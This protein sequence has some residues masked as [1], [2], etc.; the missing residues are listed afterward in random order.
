MSTDRTDSLPTGWRLVTLGDCIEMVYGKGLIGTARRA[1]PIPVY[2]SNGVVGTHDKF[3]SLG[4]TIVIGRK[5]SVGEVHFSSSPCWPIDTTY[6]INSFG[7]FDPLFLFYLLRSLRLGEL[8]KST[9]IPGLRRTD[10][11]ALRVTLPP[12]VEQRQIVK[13]VEQVLA[14]INVV[15]QRLAKVTSLLKRFRQAVLAAG[16]AGRLTVDWRSR[17]EVTENGNTLANRI[18][19]NHGYQLTGVQEHSS[20]IP[21]KWGQATLGSL[22]A[23]G[24]NKKSFVT[25]GSRGW[26]DLVGATGSYFIRS[27]C[28]NNDVLR[29]DDLVRINAPPGSESERTRV[30]VNDL[31]LTI[32]GNNVGRTATVP[33]NCPEAYVSQHVA[34]I[35]VSSEMNVRFVWLWLRSIEHGQQ[36]LQQFFY[37]YT[38]PG[39]N[40]EQVRSVIVAVPPFSEQQEIVR[41]VE[42]LLALADKIEAN[43]ISVSV[44]AEKLIQSTLAKAFRGEL[45]PTEHALAEAAEREYESAEQLL[46]GIGK[47][48]ASVIQKKRIAT[49][50][51]SPLSIGV[52][53][54]KIP[55][56]N[57]VK[58][59]HSKGIF[60]KRAAIAAYAVDRLHAKETFGRIQLEKLMYLCEAHV[61]IDLEGDY[62]RQA[63]GPLDPDIYKLENL[64]R[65]YQWFN[66]R[67]RERFGIEY[68][69]GIRIADRTGAARTLL[70]NKSQE[71]DRLLGW[72]EVMNTEQAEVFA[73]VFAAWN[74]LLID[75]T[76]AT[77]DKI[78]EQVREHWHEAKE[79]FTPERLRDCIGWIRKYKFVPCG[80]GPR[81]AMADSSPAP[82][83]SQKRRAA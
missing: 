32:T 31:L 52:G 82:D 13:K 27:E 53:Q 76:E 22:T 44:R 71:M 11:Y 67:K 74:D 55:K 9:A 20:T 78:V 61:G 69:P 37:G 12:L 24:N 7:P 80:T 77:E 72:F 14:Q 56:T 35:R 75:G 36:Q 40:L 38:K 73:T 70:G 68:S 65:K 3:V 46:A 34:I 15:R 51:T 43:V 66:S 18:I 50:E 47:N 2:G 26:A 19:R 25:S 8:D 79:R 29:L 54:A 48:D 45:V 62:R 81:T 64:A 4:P 33:P 58:K 5:G 39:L 16:C 28:I 41:R 23:P 30:R 21:D 83:A 49:N 57:I 10:V 63:A 1:G 6:F 59:K 17:V 60:F 42:N